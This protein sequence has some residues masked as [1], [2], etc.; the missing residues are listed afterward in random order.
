MQV[1]K[2]S[3]LLGKVKWIFQLS[4]HLFEMLKDLPV[5]KPTCFFADSDLIHN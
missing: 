5:F 2:H 1:T 4:D 3:E